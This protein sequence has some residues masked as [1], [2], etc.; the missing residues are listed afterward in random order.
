MDERD[1]LSPDRNPAFEQAEAR[2]FLA[3]R[4]GVVVGRIA[5]ILS[6]AANR[7]HGTRNLRFGWFDTVQS[8]EVA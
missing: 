3:R 5:A 1:T 8:Y 6:H 7:K 4:G 2:L